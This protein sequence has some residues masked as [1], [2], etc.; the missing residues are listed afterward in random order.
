MKSDAEATAEEQENAHVPEVRGTFGTIFA[1]KVTN[2][3]DILSRNKENRA[4]T[5]RDIFVTTDHPLICACN[6]AFQTEKHLYLVLE[7]CAGGELYTLMKKQDGQRFPEEVGG[8]EGQREGRRSD[9]SPVSARGAT[10]L[11][12]AY[13]QPRK[14]STPDSTPPRS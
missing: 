1:M 5:E 13:P 3:R 8:R 2:K 10:E 11:T 14:T 6:W 7:Y 4:M 12:H 9:A